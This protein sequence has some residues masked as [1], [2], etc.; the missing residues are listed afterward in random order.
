M[1]ITGLSSWIMKYNI[2]NLRQWYKD[3]AL[4]AQEAGFDIIYAYATHHYLLNN[5]Q[6][7]DIN[8]RNDE[9]GGS[10]Q[11]RARLLREI[12]EVLKDTVGETMAVAVRF[13][14]DDDQIKDNKPVIDEAQ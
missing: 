13:S 5:F 1:I 12:I 9:Y 11:N 6:R 14:P 3:A 4:R 10:V 7:S 2:P 8:D